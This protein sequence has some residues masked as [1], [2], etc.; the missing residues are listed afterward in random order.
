MK[1]LT[2]EGIVFTGEG[3]G[4]KYLSLPWVKQQIEE[5]LGF[6]PF[7]G[8]LNIKLSQ[9]S[10]SRRKQLEKTGALKICPPEGYCAGLLFKAHIGKKKCAVIIPEVEGYPENV[11]EV[12]APT[13]L[14]LAFR[15]CDKDS[16]V[17]NVQ[18]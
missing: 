6:T 14:R 11:L 18:A 12:I 16:V 7:L 10:S 13:N 2:V 15:L 4:K 1:K 9:E 5:K 8:T 3:S 17:V